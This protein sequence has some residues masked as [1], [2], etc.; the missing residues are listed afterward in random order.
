[1]CNSVE[2]WQSCQTAIPS[3]KSIL[4]EP[5]KSDFVKPLTQAR[6]RPCLTWVAYAKAFVAGRVIEGPVQVDL[7]IGAGDA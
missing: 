4:N 3:G 2:K 5:L 7:V 1:M 6:A